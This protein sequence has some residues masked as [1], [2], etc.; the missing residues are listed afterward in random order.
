MSIAN[1]MYKLICFANYNDL[2]YNKEDVIKIL[3]AFDDPTIAPSVV[4][5]IRVD[6]VV[7]QRMQFTAQNGLFS[8]TINSGR[9][10]IQLTSNDKLGFVSD[11]LPEVRNYLIESLAKLYTIFDS[12]APIPHRLAWNTSYVYFEIS[13]DEKNAY[14]NKFLR[15]LEFFKENR[16]EDTLIRYAGQREATISAEREKINVLATIN[17]Y[18]TDPGTEIEVNGFKID[19]DINTWQGNRR[20]RFEVG[21]FSEFVER[22]TEIQK[23]L[24][25]EILP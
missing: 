8:I 1:I 4:S 20:N 2:D 16:L 14:R 19:Y 3:G 6:G 10:D 7:K 11:K 18:I 17:S 21:S 23:A 13:Q 5:E 25:E 9:I 12:R 24:N 15:E 22:A